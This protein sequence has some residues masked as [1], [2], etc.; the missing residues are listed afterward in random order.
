[1]H[2]CNM[3]KMCAAVVLARDISITGWHVVGS[4]KAVDDFR[5]TP[6][7]GAIFMVVPESGPN[8]PDSMLTLTCTFA[9][10]SYL[11]S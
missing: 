11:H 5:V 1:M 3:H 7:L 4:S 10:T 6:F 9:P 2:I 8:D